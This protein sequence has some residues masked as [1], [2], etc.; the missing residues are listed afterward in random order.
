[1]PTNVVVSNYGQWAQQWTHRDRG[2]PPPFN[3]CNRNVDTT[4]VTLGALC[5]ITVRR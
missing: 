1:M 2:G 5:P 4:A 3:K